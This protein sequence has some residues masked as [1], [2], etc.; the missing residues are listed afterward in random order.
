MSFNADAFKDFCN[1][2]RLMAVKCGDCGNIFLPPKGFCPKCSSRN[3]FWM[4]ISNVGR[5]LSFTEIHVPLKGFE[6]YAPYIVVL[7]EFDCGVRLPGILRGVDL[8]SLDVGVRV[9]LVFSKDYPS[10]YYFTIL[11]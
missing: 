8:N 10:G 11:Q 3:L 2:G 4:E 6:N 9:K 7:V 5:I 1:S